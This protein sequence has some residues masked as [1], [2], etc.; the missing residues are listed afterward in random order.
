[1][2]SVGKMKS[3]LTLEPVECLVTTVFLKHCFSN[4]FLSAPPPPELDLSLWSLT[5]RT[6]ITYETKLLYFYSG[7]LYIRIYLQYF[8]L[9]HVMAIV[10]NYFSGIAHCLL[11]QV[12]LFC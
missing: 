3:S 10:F 5:L 1:M 7:D 12:E 6:A 9:Q 2:H 4:F 8:Y 11:I